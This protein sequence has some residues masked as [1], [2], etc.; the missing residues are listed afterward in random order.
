MADLPPELSQIVLSYY[1]IPELLHIGIIP[2]QSYLESI[3]ED[4]FG[5]TGETPVEVIEQLVEPYIDYIEMDAGVKYAPEIDAFFALLI[6]GRLP[7]GKR[8]GE[9][10]S[11]LIDDLTPS[12]QGYLYGKLFNYFDQFPEDDRIEWYRVF[13][14]KNPD[15]T[16]V[17]YNRVKD[18]LPVWDVFNI[19]S[20]L[21][22]DPDF[23]NSVID[24][25]IIFPIDV[26]IAVDRN[27]PDLGRML[28]D[29]LIEPT[30]I[31]K[32]AEY[33]EEDWFNDVFRMFIA[34]QQ[35]ISGL[36]DY[37]MVYRS[38]LRRIVNIDALEDQLGYDSD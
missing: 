1:T 13:V 4:V 36:Y 17:V 5:I 22:S 24:K 2:R 26:R 25:F 32:V 29:R 34:A 35:H 18:E 12:I 37:M 7:L 19:T 3:I 27:R 16:Q 31:D 14:S 15:Y 6:L 21:I 33:D 8:L 23:G 28:F 11:S 30:N 10:M 38:A 9:D 20:L